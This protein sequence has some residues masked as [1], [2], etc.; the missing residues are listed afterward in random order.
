MESI[1]PERGREL[2]QEVGIF[3]FHKW[4]ISSAIVFDSSRKRGDKKMNLTDEESDKIYSRSRY[5]PNEATLLIWSLY[6]HDKR[7]VVIDNPNQMFGNLLV[8]RVGDTNPMDTVE[9]SVNVAKFTK[10]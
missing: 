2:L 6:P 1:T 10:A 5:N 3:L 7:P 8:Q 4:D 9:L